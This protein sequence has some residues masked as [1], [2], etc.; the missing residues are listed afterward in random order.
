MIY[1][2]SV[3][4]VFP[5]F[6]EAPN[7][8]PVVTAALAVLKRTVG[9][10]HAVIVDDGSRDGTEAV[11]QRLVAANP[12]QVTLV[13]HEVNRGYGAAV[14]SGIAAALATGSDW[15][16]LT[17]SDGQFDLR[18][19]ERF[20]AIAG[21]RGIDLVTGYRGQRAD[22]R[23]RRF[24]AF[25]WSWASGVL[26]SLPVHDVDCAFKLVHRRVF[27]AIALR[28]EAAVISPELLAKA[29]RAGFRIVEVPVAHYP[30]LTG[31][32]SGA[33]LRVISR[34]LLGLAQL[35][36][37]LT[38]QSFAAS[39]HAARSAPSHEIP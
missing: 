22:S 19:L 36:L 23:L 34:S 24:N 20:L 32:A 37:S 28:G 5:A 18:E 25:L 30:R 15:L 38:R 6:N 27:Q 1:A 7:L 35:R 16:L 4:V 2:T 21:D 9:E 3:T 29:A 39:R 8:E 33:N 31:E 14:R 10:Y 17:D 11:A 12:G 13:R 26:L